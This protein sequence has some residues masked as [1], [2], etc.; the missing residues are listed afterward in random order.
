MSAAFGLRSLLR[1][2]HA[3]KTLINMKK[4]PSKKE[5]P[6]K[7]K[8]ALGE[9]KYLNRLFMINGP[10]IVV[11]LIKLVK[12]PCNSPCSL[13]GTCCAKVACKD[14]PAIPPKQ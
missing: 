10:M 2:I 1:A 8:G 9:V 4:A 13:G 14:G 7:Y 5:I 3:I 6:G 12:A 11:R